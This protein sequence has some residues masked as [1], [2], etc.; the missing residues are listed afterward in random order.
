MDRESSCRRNHGVVL[1]H[2]RSAWRF[3]RDSRHRMGDDGGVN[4]SIAPQSSKQKPRQERSSHDRDA[5]AESEL[6][7]L[8]E[9]QRWPENLDRA[10]RE[11]ANVCFRLSLDAAVEHAGFGISADRADEEELRGA[12]A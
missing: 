1:E 11:F 8:A 4:R 7:T 10:I 3:Q 6:C 12:A 5:L 9:Q 2:I